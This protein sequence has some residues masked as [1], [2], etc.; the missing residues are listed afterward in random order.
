[1]EALWEKIPAQRRGAYGAK[2]ADIADALTKSLQDG[3]AVLVKGSLG[4]KMAV[5]IE[6]LKARAGG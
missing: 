2:S 6:A 3:D 1:M 4:S 5:I